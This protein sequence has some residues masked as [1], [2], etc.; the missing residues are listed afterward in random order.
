M[1]RG[2]FAK[3]RQNRNTRSC[4]AYTMIARST[5]VPRFPRTLSLSSVAFT[6][7]ITRMSDLAV[8]LAERVVEHSLD[9]EAQL[10]LINRYIE[11][12]KALPGAR[13]VPES[14]AGSRS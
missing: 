11:E 9:R 3:L 1:K 10:E 7:T 14:T 2:R 12:V 13:G 6:S 8:T 4:G 5:F